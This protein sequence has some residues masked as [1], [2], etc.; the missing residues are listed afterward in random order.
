MRRDVYS[1]TWFQYLS[2]FQQQLFKVSV[3]L[4]DRETASSS[5]LPDHSYVVFSAAK[6]YE[7]FLKQYFYDLELID[8]KTYKGRRFRIGRAINPD[9][10]TDHRDE[11]WLYD[12]VSVSC[13]EGVARELW[14]TW[15]LC[16]NRVFHYFP[17]KTEP[18]SL[19][20]A[21]E[22]IEKLADA[23]QSAIECQSKVLQSP[24]QSL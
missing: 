20:T 22:Y 17:E 13:G 8:E 9:V 23:M 2:T 21:E 3:G 7:G 15:L 10:R 18:L 11:Y 14:E 16:R 5:Q 1:E 19:S 4:I 24:R 12:D 6:A